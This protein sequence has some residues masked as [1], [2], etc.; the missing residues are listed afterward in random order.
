MEMAGKSRNGGKVRQREGEGAEDGRREV[1]RRREPRD[2][3]DVRI[4]LMYFSNRNHAS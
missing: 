3:T 1:G 2:M 4:V